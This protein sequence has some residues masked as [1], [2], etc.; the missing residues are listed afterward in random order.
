ML[1]ASKVLLSSPA[2]NP[3]AGLERSMQPVPCTQ[4]VKD[5]LQLLQGGPS[6]QKGSFAQN[7]SSIYE[8]WA[9]T[10]FYSA[11]CFFRGPIPKTK[12]SVAQV[13]SRLAI[14]VLLQQARY[15]MQSIF[16]DEGATAPG[17]HNAKSRR[18]D[19]AGSEGLRLGSL[20]A[21]RCR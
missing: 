21:F 12:R 11:A 18:L 1:D 5:N 3:I 16:T 13:L 4:G 17:V 10:D 14:S 6:Q 9:S 8:S 2:V 15:L 20:V 7:R 19:Q